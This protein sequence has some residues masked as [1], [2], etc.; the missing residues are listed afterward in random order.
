[1]N[2]DEEILEFYQAETGLERKQIT[3]L[4]RNIRINFNPTMRK[5]DLT[6]KLIKVNNEYPVS[7]KTLLEALSKLVGSKVDIDHAIKH[8]A[9]VSSVTQESGK[10]I[11]NSLK[12]IASKIHIAESQEVLKKYGIDSS[13][14]VDVVF[15]NLVS[16]WI[17]LNRDEKVEISVGV[18]GLYQ[19]S[20]FM[21][22]LDEL[23]IKEKSF[24][25]QD[26]ADI[27]VAKYSWDGLKKETT[28]Q[29]KQFSILA[30]E[31]LRTQ[32]LDTHKNDTSA[33]K[34]ILDMLLM[35]DQLK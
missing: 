24:I 29:P 15:N 31:K 18:A 6:A 7:I 3:E 5:E 12:S 19:M 26:K 11:G 34:D 30:K 17:H 32:F 10:I 28:S 25:E 4:I 16:K 33:Q 2:K 23:S 1:M 22:L 27:N 13:L 20:R 9:I 8:I 14:P 35:I 21:I